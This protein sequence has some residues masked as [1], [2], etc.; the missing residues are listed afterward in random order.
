[1]DTWC[2]LDIM[3][4]GSNGHHWTPLDIMSIGHHVHWRFMDNN[5]HN[6]RWCSM[7][8]IGSKGHDIQ[9][10]WCPLDMMSIG[11]NEQLYPNDVH[12][13]ISFGDVVRTPLDPMDMSIGQ[14]NGVHWIQWTS[15]CPLD[16]FTNRHDVHWTVQWYPLDSPMVS[17]GYNGSNGQDSQLLR[18]FYPHA[19]D[20]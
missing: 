18:R 19:L 10:T 15:W 4:I 13:P 11:S 16:I 5:A 8:S 12:P 7:V 2:P 14:S 6:V 9:R 1:M 17:I 20:D 3:C